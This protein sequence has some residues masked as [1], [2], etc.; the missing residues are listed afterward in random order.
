[1][2]DLITQYFISTG[3]HEVFY[4]LWKKVT[5]KFPLPDNTI[6][7]RSVTRYLQNLSHNADEAVAKAKEITGETLT[8]IHFKGDESKKYHFE[9]G[10]LKFGKY[11]GQNVWDI[12]QT[13]DGF[14]YIAYII[15]NK[16]WARSNDKLFN[17]IIEN[18]EDVFIQ[19]IEDKKQ[20]WINKNKEAIN[21]LIENKD[22]NNFFASLHNTL[23]EY[24][25]CPIIN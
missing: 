22:K 9:S 21:Y 15:K 24:G 8:P 14:D 4:T 6:L 17:Y 18:F 11:C 13:R 23:N 19:R 7:T 3:E 10:D 16:M 1:M 20:E 2:T 25:D 5:I 12:I